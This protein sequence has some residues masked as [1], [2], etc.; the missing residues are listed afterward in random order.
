MLCDRGPYWCL[1]IRL[2]GTN[3]FSLRTFCSFRRGHLGFLP[4][5]KILN[6]A[7]LVSK[8][9]ELSLFSISSALIHLTTSKR[10]LIFWNQKCHSSAS[11]PIRCKIGSYTSCRLS[12]TQKCFAVAPSKLFNRLP[13]EIK[14]LPGG[15]FQCYMKR[16]SQLATVLPERNR[17]F[18]GKLVTYKS[19]SSL[20][21]NTC[22]NTPPV[23]KSIF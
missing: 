7:N 16:A 23:F 21:S 5:P 15:Q 4:Q 22:W 19:N 13:E 1:R 17:S 10:I 20:H 11:N 9:S 6:I 2:F 18:S 8:I 3:S 14:S 12:R